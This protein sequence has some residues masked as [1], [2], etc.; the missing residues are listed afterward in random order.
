MSF[1]RSVHPISDELWLE[2][3]RTQGYEGDCSA[4]NSANQSGWERK[5]RRMLKPGGVGALIVG[6]DLVMIERSDEE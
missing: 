5:M 3:C 4:S 1:R 2:T 6:T